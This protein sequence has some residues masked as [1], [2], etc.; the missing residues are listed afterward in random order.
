MT[1]LLA[2]IAA[3]SVSILT[4]LIAAGSFVWFLDEDPVEQ[5]DILSFLPTLA[6]TKYQEEEGETQVLLPKQGAV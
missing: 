1:V 6:N 5:A 2:L 3:L 4:A